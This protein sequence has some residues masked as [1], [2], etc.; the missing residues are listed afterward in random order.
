MLRKCFTTLAFATLFSSQVVHATAHNHSAIVSIDTDYTLSKIRVADYQ[1]KSV[2]IASSHK[3]TIVA[4]STKGKLLW[5]NPLSGYMNHDLWTA[6]L[7][8]D[9][10]DETLA[11]NADGHIYCLSDSG[12]LLWSFKTNDA[13]MYSVTV[14]KDK[15]KIYVLAGSYDKHL[16][17]LNPQGK[18]LKRIY[19]ADY[20]T[21]KPWGIKNKGN[22]PKGTR[23]PA[24][25]LEIANF[26]RPLKDQHNQP[27][28][29]M[30]GT[31]NSM[32]SAGSLYF[33]KPLADTPFKTV[34]LTAAKSPVGDLRIAD[35]NGDG[36]DDI[37][38]GSTKMKGQSVSI[39][40]LANDKLLAYPL[41]K[42]HKVFAEFGY[43][44]AQP[45]LVTHQGQQKLAIWYGNILGILPIHP[46]ST[47]DKIAIYKNQY[48]YNDMVKS[49]KT[50]HII[51]A[52]AQSGGSSFHIIDTQK[53]TWAD[54]FAKLEPKGKLAEML[55]NTDKLKTDLA[56][57]SVTNSTVTNSQLNPV[58]L[59][60]DYNQTDKAVIDKISA[61]YSSPVFLGYGNLRS[62]NWDRSSI[63]NEVYKNKRDKRQ[64]YDQSQQQILSK[65][66]KIY[67]D[68]P[69]AAY[70]G[71]HGNDPFFRSFDTHVKT[72]QVAGDKKTVM[73]FP[74]L[75]KYDK[76]FEYVLSDFV[77]P[78][79]DK[80][81]QTDAK[82]FLRNKH[83][84][85][86]S[87]IY[88]RGWADLV[89]GKY[90]DVFIPAMEE[91]TDKSM[92]LSIAARTGLWASGA[93]NQWGTRFS[94]DNTSFDRLRQH[95]HQMV[96]NLALRQ[97]VYHIANGATYINNF[98][99]HNEYLAVLWDL[100]GKGILYNPKPKQIL[101]Y[102]PVHLSM[103]EPDGHYVDEGNNVKWLTFSTKKSK[104][105][106]QWCLAI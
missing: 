52:S 69:G 85:W 50:G 78:L 82:M 29:V 17:Y 60:S 71:G 47:K 19:A 64:K 68:V 92:D 6:D 51:L 96:P 104:T 49:P 21:T 81:K 23:N 16:Y 37:L 35:F 103:L 53:S 1:D 101:S 2:V 7:D 57:Y 34:K 40:D 39:F 61:Q 27:I 28:I 33:F 95:S 38:M 91:T 3:G 102:S 18:Q 99:Y 59:M 4:Y 44:V 36:A 98:A 24:A 77:F 10:K 75:A 87:M 54:D 12:Q 79:A 70:W 22:Q 14:L 72:L 90:A 55:A 84:F 32:Q 73:I 106:T 94:R 42:L 74:E 105:T 30:H 20:V 41:P 97:F 25:N 58:Y 43:R 83:T 11:A 93:V 80:F 88:K 26:I 13:P 45:E 48:A 62:E 46:Q 65:A 63:K 76:D 31:M 89:S 67:Q 100:I 15:Q 5:E 86:Q 8:Q 9:G 66:K 56:N